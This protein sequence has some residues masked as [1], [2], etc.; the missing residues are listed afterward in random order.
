MTH[1]AIIDDYQNVALTLADWD[2]LGM[3][4]VTHTAHYDSPEALA[5]A[6]GHAEIV[7]A[8]RERTVFDRR[9][10]ALLPNMKLLL[11]TGARNPSIDLAAAA[12]LGITVIGS[13]SMGYPT[14]ELTWALIL[15]LLRHVPQEDALIRAGGPWQTTLGFDLKG[16]TLGTFG[17]GTLGLQ[18]TRVAQAFGMKT[19]AW[20][21]NLKPEA[22]EVAGVEYVSKEDLIRRSDILSIHTQLSR[23][24]EGAIGAAEFAMMKPT[25]FLINTSRGFIV[26]E[27]ALLAALESGQIAGAGLDVFDVEPLPLDH[28]LRR[29][30]NTVLTPHIGYVTH[31]NYR[32]WFRQIVDSIAAWKQGKVL[33]P[34]NPATNV[35]RSL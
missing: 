33:R 12:D 15:A 14:A 34:M 9:M 27:K 4:V 16:R 6:I 29:A 8:M 18:V 20:S 2:S 22:C 7:V 28:P 31:D 24:T 32:H 26:E 35:D 23:R 30:K 17:L 13:D 21:N 19:I 10:L 3:H 1:C 5:S 11:S 25:A